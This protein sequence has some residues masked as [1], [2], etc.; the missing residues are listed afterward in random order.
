MRIPATW[1]KP[2]GDGRLLILSPFDE[3]IRRPTADIARSRNLFV[4]ALADE[5]FVSHA[6]AGSKTEEFC[7]K[8]LSWGKP[9]LT[10]EDSSNS[11]L[12]SL[13]AKAKGPQLAA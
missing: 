10:L 3:K 9:V 11:R 5:V 12:I 1:K 7:K 8:I 4:A 6:A 13:G 2:L